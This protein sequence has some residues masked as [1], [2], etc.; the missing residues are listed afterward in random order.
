[1]AIHL[2]DCILR[3]RCLFLSASG[4]LI[5]VLRGV[6]RQLEGKGGAGC[7]AVAGRGERAAQFPCRKSAAVQ[8][9]A[10][11]GFAGG[12]AVAEDAGEVLGWNANAV[13][14]DG[15]FDEVPAILPNDE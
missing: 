2:W 13:I 9:E 7:R 6:T 5:G 15:D 1:M 4:L 11:A 14:N 3:V 12:E 10:V 8:A